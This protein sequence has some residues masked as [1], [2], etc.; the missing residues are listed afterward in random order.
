M[1][2][3]KESGFTLIELMLAMA[4]VGML[5]LAIAVTSMHIMNTY[6]KGITIREVNQAGRTITEDVQRSIATS[7]PFSVEPVKTGGS[8]DTTDS[9]YVERAGR[10]G[11]LCTG[12][13]TYAW[14][15]GPAL[16]EGSDRYNRYDDEES[17]VTRESIRFV[18]VTDMG[19]ILCM[20]PSLAIQRA[21]AKELLAAGDRDL[22]I[23][24]TVTVA[25]GSRDD[26]SNQ[27]LYA[28]TLVIGTNDRAEDREA[29]SRLGVSST[30]CLP[31]SEGSGFEDF[32]AINQFSIIARAGNRSGSL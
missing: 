6:T 21:L 29:R 7:I 15:Y 8:S 23:Q 9:M 13:Y 26:A 11:R 4:F 31:P 12:T 16:V 14:N 20:N 19:G 2:R 25:A 28:I 22:A 27:A 17:Q 10:G 32:C 18:K 30:T 24:D 5:L 3:N 1:I